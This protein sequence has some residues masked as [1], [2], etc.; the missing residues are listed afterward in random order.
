MKG[1]Q[2]RCGKSTFVK[3]VKFPRMSSFDIAKNSRLA[4]K[5][6]TFQS[7]LN[8]MFIRLKRRKRSPLR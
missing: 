7:V 6:E 4:G 8:E 1:I 5:Y 3:V 2:R